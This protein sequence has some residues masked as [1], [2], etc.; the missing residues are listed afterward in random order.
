MTLELDGALVG[1]INN[2]TTIALT[3]VETVTIKVK[4]PEQLNLGGI[5]MDGAASNTNTL[6]ITGNRALTI[7][8]Q[9]IDVDVLDASG[10]SEGGSVTLNAATGRARNKKVTYTGSTGSDQ[11]VMSNEED[12]LDA[13][14]EGAGANGDTL[15][16]SANV[17]LLIGYRC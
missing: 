16:V 7:D 2:N 6:K 13:G 12:I 3:D 15:V 8:G 5:A 9:S 4:D 14:S 10:M 11:L 1:D 17:E